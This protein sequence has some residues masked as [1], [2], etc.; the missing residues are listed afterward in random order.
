MRDY[1]VAF[2]LDNEQQENLYYY[3]RMMD[4]AFLKFNK[5]K[6]PKRGKGS[7]WRPI[8]GSSPSA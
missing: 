4:Q 3:V 6:E 2:E 7:K 1:V 8:S 5:P